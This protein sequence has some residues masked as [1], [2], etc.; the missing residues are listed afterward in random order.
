MNKIEKF[1]DQ[2]IAVS[3]T[4][5]KH[6]FSSDNGLMSEEVKEILSNPEDTE[7][8]RKALKEVEETQKSVTIT[9]SNNKTLTL[10][11]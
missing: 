3:S 5:F 7:K 4:L 6:V 10:V 1:I 9:L 2:I 8:Y 11:N